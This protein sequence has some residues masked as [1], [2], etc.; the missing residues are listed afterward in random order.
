MAAVSKLCLVNVT[1]VGERDI[2]KRVRLKDAVPLP[3][4][5]R[6]VQSGELGSSP[7]E[8]QWSCSY[9]ATLR[10]KDAGSLE[11]SSVRSFRKHSD[12]V[13]SSQRL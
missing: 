1:S 8:D 13:S 5:D 4:S 7:T 9:C 12:R 2:N 11:S 6:S 3:P 10:T